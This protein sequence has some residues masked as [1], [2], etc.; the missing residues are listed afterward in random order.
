MKIT[1]AEVK[2][3]ASLARL[4]LDA[5]ITEQY[6]DQISQILAYIDKL[7]EVNTEG[8]KPAL[9]VQVVN[10]FR[11]DEVRPSLNI[12]DVLANAPDKNANE[13]IVPKILG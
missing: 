3:V 12:E 11:E 9:A 13:F 5:A 7:N 10:A 8:V 1:H 2:H 4:N 6:A